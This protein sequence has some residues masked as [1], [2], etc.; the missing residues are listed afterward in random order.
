[1]ICGEYKLDL[2]CGP[3]KREGFIGLD[4]HDYSSIHPVGEFRV[5]NFESGVLPFCDNSAV[6][7]LADSVLEHLHNLIPFMND[8]WRVLKKDGTFEVIV[9]RGG[10]ETS[11]KDPTHVRFFMEKTFLY[12]TKGKRQDNYGI[13]PWIIKEQGKRGDTDAEIT[14]ILTPDK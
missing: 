13:K 1:M 7:L 2:G 4:L 9:P 6:A 14:M 11:F 5:A 3:D 12:F 8:C 10:S